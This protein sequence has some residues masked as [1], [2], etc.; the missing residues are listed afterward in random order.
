MQ[1]SVLH[2][3]LTL[4]DWLLNQL[5]LSGFTWR[6]KNSLLDEMTRI[7]LRHLQMACQQPGKGRSLESSFNN[8]ELDE[9]EIGVEKG[10]TIYSPSIFGGT[11]IN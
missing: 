11:S 4:S 10:E 1:N 9:L 5:D 2:G 8:V 7:I 6:T 3:R